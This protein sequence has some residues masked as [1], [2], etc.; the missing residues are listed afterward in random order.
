[1][2]E[3]EVGGEEGGSLE[4]FDDIYL[5]RYWQ[6]CVA[7]LYCRPYSLFFCSSLLLRRVFSL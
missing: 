4:I 1:M 3:V 6:D 7:V 5:S 2:G